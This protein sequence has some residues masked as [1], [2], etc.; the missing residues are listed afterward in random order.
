MN[1]NRFIFHFS[2]FIWFCMIDFVYA[3]DLYFQNRNRSQVIAETTNQIGNGCSIVSIVKRNLNETKEEVDASLELYDSFQV[4]LETPKFRQNLILDAAVIMNSSFQR[5]M[6]TDF[7]KG[8]SKRDFDLFRLEEVCLNKDNRL[9]ILYSKKFGFS[10]TDSAE[11][12]LQVWELSIEKK[13]SLRYCY[14]IG[15]STDHVNAA[16]FYITTTG[17]PYAVLHTA[18]E[19]QFIFWRIGETEAVEEEDSPIPIP[20]EW[21]SMTNCLISVSTNRLSGD[22]SFV[23][24]VERNYAFPRPARLSKEERMKRRKKI[25]EECAPVFCGSNE[26]GK[27]NGIIVIVRDIR[28]FPSAADRYTWTILGP[29]GRIIETSADERL[30]Y[31][32][33]G[34]F[35]SHADT[36]PDRILDVYRNEKGYIYVASER[37]DGL[38]A[39]V[40]THNRWRG[41]HVNTRFGIVAF[42]PARNAILHPISKAKFYPFEDS[43]VL[44]IDFED[45]TTDYWKINGLEAEKLHDPPHRLEG[46]RSELREKCKTTK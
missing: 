21:Q 38:V 26:S 19:R 25:L 32:A 9:L 8:I 28:S 40:F 22:Y 35:W 31:S 5:E 13:A 37:F 45:G 33:Q 30:Y 44:R 29:D 4:Y 7:L 20:A 34:L 3:E 12:N 41:L 11:Y 16:K 14:Q 43:L 10:I 36:E 42:R 18:D 1:K 17:I 15:S 6:K 27:T 46:V 24:K 2:Y 39:D 23:S